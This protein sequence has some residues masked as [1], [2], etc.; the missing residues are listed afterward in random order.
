MANREHTLILILMLCVML[1]RCCDVTVTTFEKQSD[2]Y[3][4]TYKQCEAGNCGNSSAARGGTAGEKK[5][6]QIA[7]MGN[8]VCANRRRR[9]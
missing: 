2:R 8:F 5:G 4:H 3:I 1:K 9:N 7:D 6:P